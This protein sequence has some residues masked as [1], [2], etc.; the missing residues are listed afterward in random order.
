MVALS[1]FAGLLILGVAL[2]A[3]DFDGLLDGTLSDAATGDDSEDRDEVDTVE[4][5]TGN[6]L[7]E[8]G[9]DN[10][11]V[12]ADD[13][14]D[15]INAQGGADVVYAGE[16][17]D[18]IDG[19]FGDDTLL[20]EDGADTIDA[21]GGLDAVFGGIG[22]DEIDGGGGDDTILGE[23]GDDSILGRSGS[24]FVNG[25]TG[26]DT[27]KGGAGDDL[28]VGYEDSLFDTNFEVS[29]TYDPDFISGGAGTDAIIAGSGDT[30]DGGD[31]IDYLTLGSWIDPNNPVHI[32]EFEASE[33]I[34]AIIVPDDYAG[35]ATVTV[36]HDTTGTH[37]GTVYL[38]GVRL[39]EVE[40]GGTL[41]LLDASVIAVVYQDNFA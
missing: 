40:G 33:D 26:E 4:G 3:F 2:G 27:L 7:L 38:D 19:G 25:G 12:N 28:L 34:I 17:D 31:G 14:D 1:I 41:G 36:V 15:T 6:D 13:G 18:V 20:G 39:A 16:G 24:D 11:D 21:G 9:D 29:D 22:D 8:T 10:D 30:I 23:A 35:S 37:S 32:E 5:S